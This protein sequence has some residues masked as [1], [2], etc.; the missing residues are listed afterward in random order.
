MVGK[1][2]GRGRIVITALVDLRAAFDSVDRRVLG[3][4]L[5]RVGV[6]KRLRERIMEIYQETRS[7]VRVGKIWGQILDGER[8]KAGGI[9]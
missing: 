2:L 5:R 4:S 8:G 9:H 7:V 6:S 3:I 1:E